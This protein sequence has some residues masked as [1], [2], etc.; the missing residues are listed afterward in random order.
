MVKLHEIIEVPRP[1]VETFR[2]TSDFSFIEQWDPGVA[3]S[4]K[5]TPGPVALGT[6]YRLII[7]SGLRRF[8]MEYMIQ[9]YEPPQ[10]VVL[11]GQAEGLSARDDIRFEALAAGTR[12]DYTAELQFEGSMALIEPWLKGTLTRIGQRAMAGLKSALSETPP[13]PVLPMWDKLADHTVLWG[14]MGFSK[15]G[16]QWRKPRWK[17]LAVSL[18]GRT[19]VVTGATAGLGRAVAQRLAYLGARVILVGR[20][21]AKL[22]QTRE[23]LV[24]ATGNSA[25][26]LQLADLS[27]LQDVRRLASR[28]IE[29]ESQIHVLINNAGA[30]FNQREMTPEG[31]ERSFA[32]NLLC[33][34]LLTQLLIPHLKASQPAR[35]I[36]VS[37]GGMYT[38][39]LRVDDLQY[40]RK[41]YNGVQA[42][43]HAKRAQVI[44]TEL[45]AEQ[46]K[47]SGVVVHAM[48]PGWADTPGLQESLPTFHRWTKRW[49]RTPEEGADT[50]VWLAA[51]HEAAQSTGL[52]WLDREPHSPYLLPGT[53][54]S[55]R[56]R[57]QLWEQLNHWAAR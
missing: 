4:V 51:A 37:S 3:E 53:K 44:L 17:P 13:P 12:I 11:S 32:V 29:W 14:M 54:E 49:L 16:Y 28:L 21:A 43:A 7:C 24:T 25:I 27:L 52:F 9:Q 56:E 26:D 18:Q 55:A 31:F 47:G 15:L 38:Q 20:D 1:L 36:N 57:M 50:I 5:L 48:H 39:K 2:Y 10:R 8:P 34:F 33:P 22:E 30:L 35:I 19:V 40:E 42:Y 45:W 6:R 23:A 46:L 41:P